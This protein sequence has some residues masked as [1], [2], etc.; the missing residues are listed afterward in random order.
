MNIL[1]FAIFLFFIYILPELTECM[2]DKGKGI[3]TSGRGAT[4]QDIE[5]SLQELGE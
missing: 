1:N 4:G 2:N 3:D 5:R